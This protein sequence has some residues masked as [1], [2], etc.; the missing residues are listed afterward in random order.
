MF[1]ILIIFKIFL[2]LI[3][4]WLALGVLKVF[5]VILIFLIDS[6]TQKIKGNRLYWGWRDIKS[7]LSGPI[8]IFR[9][10]A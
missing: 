2:G 4:L 8:P 10:I 5:L 6:M 9:C 7:L 1:I 3:L